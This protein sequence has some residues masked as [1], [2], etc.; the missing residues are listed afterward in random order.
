LKTGPIPWDGAALS[1]PPHRTRSID[2]I[3]RV[4]GPPDDPDAHRL[5]CDAHRHT[6]PDKAGGR[7]R[8]SFEIFRIY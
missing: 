2:P 4:D 7:D 1:K 5:V 3:R 8:R 6:D